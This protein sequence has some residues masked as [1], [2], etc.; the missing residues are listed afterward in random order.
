M[1][2]PPAGSGNCR[3]VV[4]GGQISEHRRFRILQFF[5]NADKYTLPFDGMFEREFGSGEK[6]YRDAQLLLRGK[7]AWICHRNRSK[8]A[9]LQ[10]WLDGMQQHAGYNHTWDSLHGSPHPGNVAR[11]ADGFLDRRQNIE[12]SCLVA[13]EP[14]RT[15]YC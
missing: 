12:W 14:M 2:V 6:A 10:P 3:L 7:A 8:Q 13:P 11:N 5:P 15:H 4:E 1:T 9:S